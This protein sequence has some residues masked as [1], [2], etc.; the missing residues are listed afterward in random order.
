MMAGR[1][2]E[3]VA[4]LNTILSTPKIDIKKL[5]EICFEGIPD[6]AGFRSLCWKILLN[7]LP[8][9]RSKWKTFL[10]KERAK[11]QNFISDIIVQ[12]SS[13]KLNESDLSLDHPLN[14]DPESQWQTF[15]KDNEVLL[16]IDRD[17]RRLCPDISFFQHPTEYPASYVGGTYKPCETLRKRVEQAILEA[18]EIGMS[19][20]GVKNVKKKRA[21]EYALLPEGQEAHWEVVERMLFI[22]AKLNPGVGYV[23]GMNEVIG[24]IYNVLASDPNK[25]WQAHAEADAFF[26]FAHLMG[27]IRDNFL[28]TLDDSACGIG[29]VMLQ[30]FQFLQCSDQELFEDLEKKSIKPQFFAFRWITLLLSQEFS[31]PDVIRLWDSLFSDLDRID[32]ILHVCCA[33]LILMRQRLLDSDFAWTMKLLQN[34]PSDEYDMATIIRKADELRKPSATTTAPTGKAQSNRGLNLK[35]RLM[36]F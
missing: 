20:L 26:C 31:L 30:L 5:R 25:E 15:F 19:R 29:N 36:L 4:L 8:L 2:Q 9:D 14:L 32:F 24:P 23:Q 1:Y 33:M 3:R 28:K 18:S 16:Q 27:E 35:K 6:K 7:Y 13:N 17:V 34:F 11:Y 21:E 10:E 22:Y 12:P